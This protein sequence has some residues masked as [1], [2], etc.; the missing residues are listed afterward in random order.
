MRTVRLNQESRR[1]RHWFTS[2]LGVDGAGDKWGPIEH[3]RQEHEDLRTRGDGKRVPEE[4]PSDVKG[5]DQ[6]NRRYQCGAQGNSEG[7]YEYTNPDTCERLAFN[8]VESGNG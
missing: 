2:G 1:R 7:W 5:Q 3:G 6:W 4:P 8:S